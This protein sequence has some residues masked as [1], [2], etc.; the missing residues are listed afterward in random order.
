MRLVFVVVASVFFLEAVVMLVI[1]FFPSL[2]F[3]A[4]V[5]V[6]AVALTFLSLPLF[7]FFVYRPMASQISERRR[8][9][10]VL[11]EREEKSQSLLEQMSDVFWEVDSECRYVEVTG[12]VR[13]VFGLDP[14]EVA[15]RGVFDFI[16]KD[17][18]RQTR[19]K[20][21]AIRSSRLPLRDFEYRIVRKNGAIASL[22]VNAVPI[23][24][25]DGAFAGYRGIIRDIT[26]RKRSEEALR[27]SEMKY[28]IIADNNYD[29]EFWI[30][31]RGHFL[32]SSPSCERI[33][34]YT[35]REF[36]ENQNLMGRIVHPDDQ[37][38]FSEYMSRAMESRGGEEAEFRIIS[39]DGRTR[40]VAS[41]CQPIHDE[42]GQ[43][44]GVRGSN[45]DVTEKKKTEAEL[46]ES[47]R[48]FREIVEN[49]RLAAVILDLNGNIFYL[50]DYTLDL[51]GYE[52]GELVGRD[53]FAKL[54]D[55]AEGRELKAFLYRDMEHGRVPSH[56]T[57]RLTTRDGG[58]LVISWNNTILK[59]ARGRVI[60]VTL[61]GED[62]TAR[63]R[64]EEALKLAHDELESR[65]RERTAELSSLIEQSPMAIA[66]LDMDGCLEQVNSAWK[67]FYNTTFGR[68]VPSGYRVFEDAALE[69]HGLA[70]KV[71]DVFETGKVFVSGPLSVER[72]D[73]RGGAGT[74]WIVTRF[75]GVAGEDGKVRRVINM[76]EDITERKSSE[77][78][79]RLV[80]EGSA[81]KTGEGF[82][83]D[84]V[85]SLAAALGVRYVF[86]AE[87][88]REKEKVRTIAFWENEKFLEN[89]EYDLDATPCARVYETREPCF[90]P[91]D[92]QALF[93]G[94][95]MLVEMEAES[96]YGV[97]ILSSSGE[98]L[99]HIGILDD[100]PMAENEGV[101][102]ILR[103]FAAR[104][105][106]ELVRK[107]AEEALRESHET[108]AAVMD[109]IDAAIY[110]ADMET[111]E[112]LFANRY[113]KDVFGDV[114]GKTCWKALQKDQNGPCSF[115]SNEKL[116]T[117]DGE[118]AGVYVWELQNTANG[119]WYE[120]HDRAIRWIDGRVAR[121]EVA[122]DITERKRMEEAFSQLRPVT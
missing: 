27:V 54:T 105:C 95:R 112:I 38:T 87:L 108:M 43:F 94:D 119:R 58:R 30:S 67:D 91:N 106:S 68:P 14:D 113:L 53:F 92:V 52:R 79:L 114:V 69:R 61:I 100:K 20:C 50:N 76:V 116:V 97:P 75:S 96:Y 51:V 115:C 10:E 35:A 16:P 110:V 15:G 40:V 25:Q 98:A 8:V 46:R 73:G 89:L 72:D 120:I 56:N 57:G 122:T 93:P 104:A 17:E 101:E 31:P 63:R 18:A 83:R 102:S 70:S 81:A 48:R 12:A 42:D 84:F 71:R 29:W 117:E 4:M 107:H 39:R 37:E 49:T 103:I 82:F 32:H 28:R 78:A 2:P 44:L 64:A 5:L 66:V 80:S 23:I 22:L 86:I 9:E 47:E 60:G 74:R 88:A 24:G 62:I 19:E 11:R 3:G 85:R 109:G 121:M 33:T 41:L 77:E 111:Y 34:G 7:Y 26:D 59:D 21:E 6:D 65:V 13:G 55:P 90:Y 36:E 45:R 1:R 99:G 118:P